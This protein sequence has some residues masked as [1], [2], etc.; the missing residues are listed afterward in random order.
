MTD[1]ISYFSSNLKYLRLKNNIDQ[2][3]LAHKLGRKSASTI[4]EWESGK[5]TPKQDLVAGDLTKYPLSDKEESLQDIS[6]IS[7]HLDSELKQK[8]IELG[9]ELLNKQDKK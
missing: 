4:S 1:K 5:Y 2:L 9:Q 6:Y 8:W 7:E 3:E